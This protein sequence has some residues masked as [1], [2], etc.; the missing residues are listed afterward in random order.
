MIVTNSVLAIIPARGGSRRVSRKNLRALGGAPLLHWTIAAA[1]QSRYID[2]LI[3]SSEDA[4]IQ[5]AARLLGCE[6]PFSRPAELAADATP[7][8]DPVLHAIE[9]LP[10][11]EW[12]V[13]LQPTSPLRIASDIDR[14]IELCVENS[15]PACVSMMAV[16]KSPD[17]YYQIGEH[18]AINKWLSPE[19]AATAHGL[20][21][22]NGAVYVARCEWLMRSR[23]FIDQETIAYVMPAARSIDIDSEA[24]LELAGALLEL[25]R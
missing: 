5:E 6:V 3:L 22:L 2:R 12:V 13:L 11:Y 19:Q 1:K 10:G 20:H 23:T 14:C 7:G 16:E 8:I 24:D 4:E 9:Q 15:A 18:G 17:W 25:R 21:V